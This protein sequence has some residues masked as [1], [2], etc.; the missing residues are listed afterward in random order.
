MQP[1]AIL[2][3]SLLIILA[4]AASACTSTKAF[5]S[6]DTSDVRA[7]QVTVLLMPP[8]VELYEKTV[9]GVL[10]PKAAWTEI[11]RRNVDLALETLLIERDCDFVRY[12][13]LGEEAEI[14]PEHVQLYKRHQAVG[15][16]IL[17][18]KYIDALALPTKDDRFD[19]SLGPEAR[20]LKETYG[21]DYALFVYF[22]DSFSTPGRVATTI[23]LSLFTYGAGG[24]AMGGG[25]QVGFA[26]MIDL[27]SGDI[28][29]FNVLASGTGDLRDEDRAADACTAILTD[30]P[31]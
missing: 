3:V 5:E 31:V 13:P 21:A 27:E 11:A 12:G 16:A 20:E 22:R 7:G 10:E 23:A 28:V 1:R 25:E 2:T 8:D 9:G 24:A 14:R 29:W 19:W 30:L 18:H 26:S 17:T 4:A 6:V 15:G